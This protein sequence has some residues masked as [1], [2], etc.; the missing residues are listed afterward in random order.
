MRSTK[1]ANLDVPGYIVIILWVALAF[2]IITNIILVRKKFL[3]RAP[4]KEKQPKHTER[5]GN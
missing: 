1:M 2:S 3:R 4:N 5:V